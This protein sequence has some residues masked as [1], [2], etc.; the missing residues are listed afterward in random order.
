ML[1]DVGG[2]GFMSGV[3]DLSACNSVRFLK[4]PGYKNLFFTLC[5][6]KL[7]SVAPIDSSFA[8]CIYYPLSLVDVDLNLIDSLTSVSGLNPPF[9]INNKSLNIFHK[10][11]D[12]EIIGHIDVEQSPSVLNLFRR[13]TDKAVEHYVVLKTTCLLMEIPKSLVQPIPYQN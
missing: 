2:V 7:V 3:L 1:Q 5:D 10:Y 4:I 8:G 13:I 11:V 9:T 6:D 12:P